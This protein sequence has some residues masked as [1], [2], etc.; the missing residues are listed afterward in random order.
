MAP[1]NTGAPRNPVKIRNSRATVTG[2]QSPHHPIHCK[3]AV[4]TWGANAGS[5]ILALPLLVARPPVYP[6]KR[7]QGSS[8]KGDRR[9]M[10]AAYHRGPLFKANTTYPEEKT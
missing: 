2:M 4:R 1:T 7:D 6:V 8:A 10:A 9:E 3:Q 5:P